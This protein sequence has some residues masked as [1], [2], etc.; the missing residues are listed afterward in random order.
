MKKYLGLLLFAHL[1]TILYAQ[2]QSTQQ[3]AGGILVEQTSPIPTSPFYN[4]DHP[5]DVFWDDRFTRG[6]PNGPI[7]SLIV[8]EEGRLYLGGGFS[9]VGNKISRLVA[10]WDGSSWS[11]LGEGVSGSVAALVLGENDDLFVAGNFDSAGGLG[12]KNIAKWDGAEWSPL[13]EG[14]NGRTRA[15]AFDG[16]GSL[17]AGGDIDSAG[18]LA[19]NNI[20]KWDGIAWSSLGEGI[21]GDP[22]ENV[23]ALAIDANDNLFVGGEFEMAG[24]NPAKNIAMWDGRSWSEVGGGLY[25]DHTGGI[26]RALRFDDDGNLYAGGFFTKSGNKQVFHIAKWDGFQWVAV[27]SG[28]NTGVLSLETDENGDVYAGGQFDGVINPFRDNF[29][30]IARWDGVDWFQLGSGLRGY[31]RSL[32]L[33]GRGNLYAGGAFSIAGNK[34]S[35]GIA[36]WDVREAAIA[37]SVDPLLENQLPY[38]FTSAYPNPFREYTTLEIT[39]NEP[40]HLVISVYDASGRQVRQLFDG[41]SLPQQ[42][43]KIR[44]DGIGLASGTYFVHAH[45][46][47]FSQSQAVTFIK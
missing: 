18:V 38:I 37:T 21:E 4:E 46:E 34:P 39:V 28:F 44:L 15:L 32:A 2:P 10:Q 20:A 31:P 22:F 13:A 36:R 19:V 8:N 16:N 23:Y 1:S 42:V 41:L 11:G 26:V 14:L 47:R 43:H 5:D 17:Y 45:G 27:G 33:D 30:R 7:F 29:N 35:A 3:T 25:D 24:G 12:A 40:Q 6:G 9:T